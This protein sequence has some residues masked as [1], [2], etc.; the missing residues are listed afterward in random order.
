MELSWNEHYADKS[1]LKDEVKHLLEAFIETLLN[2]IPE[3]EIEAV[4]H[5]G[6]AQKDWETPIDYVPELSDVDIHLLF[7]NDSSV[8]RYM[9]SI[10]QTINIQAEVERR[11]FTK[12]SKPLHVPRPQLIILNRFIKN[13][14]Y[15]PAPASVVSV[16]YG[17]DYPEPDYS[18]RD[19]IV[20]GD[21]NRLLNEKEYLSTFPFNVIDRLSKYILESLRTLVWRVS[22]A[23]SR[24]LHILG[25]PTEQAW[26]VNRTQSVNLLEE[27][28]DV[29]FAQDY[30]DFYLSGWE[31]FLS[32]YSDSNAGRS[33]LISGVKALSR[34][35]EIAETWSARDSS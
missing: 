5:K 30:A 31:Y 32:G 34:A 26:G 28:G 7:S 10:A 6:S 14:D 21:C 11:Y 23:G 1:V 25:L 9:G 4:Y 3:S 8:D 2:T 33:S 17:K 12:V 18:D 16:L 24:I 29:H 35:V 13:V 27:M 19:K 20:L 15:V 22:P